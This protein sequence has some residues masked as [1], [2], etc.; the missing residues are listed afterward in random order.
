MKSFDVNC[1]LLS[2]TMMFAASHSKT[3]SIWISLATLSTVFFATVFARVRFE[4]RPAIIT[5]NRFSS[6]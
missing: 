5:M 2:V 6:L 1:V 4:K 3:Q